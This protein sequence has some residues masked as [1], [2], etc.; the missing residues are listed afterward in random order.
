MLMATWVF[1]PLGYLGYLN[2]AAVSVGIY[3]RASICVFDYLSMCLKVNL[4]SHM[5]TL[6]VT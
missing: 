5:V 6:Y 2:K 3:V 1:L 4:L